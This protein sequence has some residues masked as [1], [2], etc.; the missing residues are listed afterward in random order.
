MIIKRYH[1]L[2]QITFLPY[3]FPINCFVVEQE[4]DLICIDMGVGKFADTVKEMVHQTGKPLNTLILTHAH[5]DHVNGIPY[6]KKVFPEVLVGISKRDSYLL[7]KDFRLQEDEPDKPVK[8]GFPKNIIPIDFT[9]E[10]GEFIDSLEVI[11]SPGHTPGAVSF[12]E[13]QHR[14][15]IAGD[16]FQTRGGLAVSGV[17][18]WQFPFPKIATWDRK[19]AVESAK[20]LLDLNPELLAVGHGNML[21]Q[22]EEQ[23]KKAIKV[24]ERGM[25]K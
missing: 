20:K 9:F 19:M 16:A 8:G 15:L 25:E 1:N 22:P 7:K 3:L 13:P 11:S 17:L 12:F 23:M 21:V 6:F 18:K 24:A 10:S 5:G 14:M 4:A 2:Y